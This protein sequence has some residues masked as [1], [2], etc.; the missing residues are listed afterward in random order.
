MKILFICHANVC[1]S[2]MAQKILKKELPSADVFSRG[3]YVDPEISVPEKVKDFLRQQK[4]E[5]SPHV[6]TQL[7]KQ[8]LET[9]DFIF[10]MEVSH[11]DFLCDKYAQYTDKI[12]L[13]NEFAFGEETDMEDPIFLSGSSFIKQAQLLQKAVLKV[14]E[15][16]KQHTF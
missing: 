12:W 16:L 3:L 5:Y 15:K 14:A 13:L 7:Q 9:A 8:D 1:R 11:F 6:A 10:C 2:F 4:I